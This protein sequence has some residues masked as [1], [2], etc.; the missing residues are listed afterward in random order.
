VVKLCDPELHDGSSALP[1]KI[2]D[3]YGKDEVSDA[4]EL[5]S[6]DRWSLII[7]KD[8]LVF[9]W[10]RSARL[11]FCVFR[12]LIWAADFERYATQFEDRRGLLTAQILP[13]VLVPGIQAINSTVA[14]SEIKSTTSLPIL[15]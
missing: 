1:R 7:G 10:N 15:G 8:L 5:N 13:S 2:F 6:A 11:W 4:Y 14:L 3:V 12:H 9:T